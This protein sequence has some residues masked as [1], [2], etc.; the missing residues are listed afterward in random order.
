MSMS[1][2]PEPETVTLHGKGDFVDVIKLRIL[3]LGDNLGLSDRAQYNYKSPC[4]YKRVER[5]QSEKE[6]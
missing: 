5:S 3:R 4:I 6:I 1:Q 2:F